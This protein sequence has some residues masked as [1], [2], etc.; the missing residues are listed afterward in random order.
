M[1][2]ERM[3]PFR[4]GDR[5]VG[6]G[7]ERGYDLLIV[8][9]RPTHGRTDL[10]QGSAVSV[11]GDA[12]RRTRIGEHVRDPV[13]RI[14]RIHR[15][16][17]S[18]GLRHRPH[19]HD[20][21]DRPRQRQRHERTRT[22]TTR[23]Q[24]TRQPRRRRIQLAVRHR[25]V[26]R[27]ERRR[28]D[29]RAID[30]TAQNLRQQS[31][32]DRRSTTHR[33]QRRA[34]GLRQHVDVADD[35]VA[36][37]GGHIQDAEKPFGVAA[38]DLLVQNSRVVLHVDGDA[39]RRSECIDV[40]G[41]FDHEID[42]V[43]VG[44]PSSAGVREDDAE[45]CGVVGGDLAG[46]VGEG[47]VAVSERRR[48]D[49]AQPLRQRRERLARVDGTPQNHGV[50]CCVRGSR[51]DRDVVLAGD[52]CEHGG[53]RG[54]QGHQD[55]RTLSCCRGQQRSVRLG[56]ELHAQCSWFPR[57]VRGTRSGQ[58]KPR[59]L[60]PVGEL[61][62]PVQQ[63][64]PL[65]TPACSDR[66]TL[67]MY[68]VDGV[69]RARGHEGGDDLDERTVV[70]RKVFVDVTVR[71][72]A[73]IDECLCGMATLVDV[74]QEVVDRAGR[75]DVE[76]A[77]DR[78]EM[79][80]LMEQHHVDH[81]GNQRLVDTVA[82][83]VTADVLDAEPLVAER[84]HQ[85]ELH[86]G[87]EIADC[88][89]RR[90][91]HRN[92]RDVHEHSARTAQCRSRSRGHRHVDENVLPPGHAGEITREGRDDD[93]RSRGTLGRVGVLQCCDH[94]VGQRRA[95]ELA[96]RNRRAGVVG[97]RRT[98]VYVADVIG[99]VLPIRFEACRRA[100]CLIHLVQRAE[101]GRFGRCRLAAF[102]LGGVE[103]GGSVDHRHGAVAVE[104][105]MVN[106]AVPQ[107]S[108][109]FD[110]QQRHGNQSVTCQIDW[111]G[112]V[113]VDPATRRR[114]RVRFA[115][116]VDECNR[117]VDGMVDDLDRFAVHLDQL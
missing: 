57:S 36:V 105:D 9:N 31:L 41:G 6:M 32:A 23:D 53:D 95:L 68:V 66:C 77:D 30:R 54:V 98:V 7:G 84:T 100:V 92:G 50:P 17:R 74:D 8:E 22:H 106:L 45:Q 65:D 88:P 61:G 20:R 75:D 28:V 93:R 99:P 114:H 94:V 87:D 25:P 29:A 10:G 14:R 37:L 81:R 24:Q 116:E 13:H 48:I 110:L 38:D 69:V 26:T 102:D 80:L 79:D 78:T 109:V 58:W 49:A 59:R 3:Y 34:L 11:D 111:C 89:V 91:G 1:K 21:L 63:L 52:A 73:E 101:I 18:T 19:R 112:V 16:E 86:L 83:Q 71:V 117:V 2:R 64:L 12:E 113:F 5:A 47:H 104:R 96:G 46:D 55:T 60:G 72:T 103:L 43:E 27:H 85:F 42:A 40:L 70:L 44:Q 115:P 51:A 97:Q 90:H 56:P 39:C 62:V 108:I 67:G 15:Q 76:F 82:L 107:V 35:G 4:V 33:H